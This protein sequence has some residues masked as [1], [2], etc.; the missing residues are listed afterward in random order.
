[1][2]FIS[3]ILLCVVLVFIYL[4]T[5]NRNYWKKKNI[6]QVEDLLFKFIFDGRS[7]PEIYKEIYDKY[8][9]PYIGATQACVPSLILKTLEDI[10]AVFAGDFQSFH[11]RGIKSNSNDTLA[12][13]LLLVDNFPRWKLMRQKLSPVF[14]SAKLKNMFYILDKCA[15]DFVSFVE[16]D[17]NMRKT[18]FNVLYTYTTASIG[19]SVF[20]IDTQTKDTMNSPF[21]DMAWKSVGPSLKTNCIVA[22]SSLFPRLFYFLKLK[23]FGDHEDFF[24]G[25]VKK[26]LADRRLNNNTKRHDFIETCLELQ[27]NG[28]MQDPTTGYEIVPTDEVIAGQAFF[29]F[30]AGADT[31]A[32]AMHFTL[33]ELSSNQK[34]LNKLHKEIDSIFVPGKSEITYKDIENLPYLDMVLNEAIRKYPPVGIIARECTRDTVLPSGVKIEKGNM[35][36]VPVFA[37]QRDEKYFRNPE[38]F[39]PDRFGPNSEEIKNYSNLPFGEG[40]RICI[41]ESMKIKIFKTKFKIKLHLTLHFL[42]FVCIMYLFVCVE[43]LNC[44]YIVFLCF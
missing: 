28:V 35:V 8:D 9:A 17:Q 5:K 44:L 11:R 29:F 21:L 4:K 14:T 18:P 30:I 12:D 15:R 6:I 37:I 26:V 27:K 32:N 24:V 41:G 42:L 19:A 22:L 1:M 43:I 13:N 38:E 31:S 10:Q 25:V 16:N 33:L 34:V 36:Q 23:L 39:N 20:G 40:N 3:L 2:L 7:M